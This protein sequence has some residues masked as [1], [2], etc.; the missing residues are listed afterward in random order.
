MKIDRIR[1]QNFHCFEDREF[2]FGSRFNLIIGD[3]ATGKTTLLD[4]LSV[5]LGSLFLGFPEPAAPRNFT[6]D[7][8]RLATYHHGDTWTVEPQFPT[9]VDCSGEVD[10]H[11]GTWHRALNSKDGR[12]TRQE[13]EWIRAEASRLSEAVKQGRPAIL[14]VVSYYGT[15]RLW[16]QLRQT[17]TKA[18]QVDT[19]KPDTRFVGYLD[20]LN[21]AS[22]VKRL[23]EWFKTQEMSALQRSTT[24]QTLEAARRAILSCVPGSSF[25]EFDVSRDQLMI[26]FAEK[27]LPFSFLSDGYRN[28]VAMAADIAIRCASLNPHLQ[29]KSSEETPGV[30]LIDEIDLHLHPRWQRRVVDDLLRTFPKIQFFGTTHSPFVIQSLPP[31]E[32]VQLLNLDDEHAEEFAHKSVEDI[33][34]EIQGVELPQRSKR[35]QDMMHAAERY[36]ALLGQSPPASEEER[37]RLKTE[38]DQLSMPFSD[39]PAYQAFLKVQRTAAGMNGE[40]D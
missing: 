6:S 38:L 24:S 13:A 31:I 28:M 17:K 35:F 18:R 10:G 2:S 40:A 25:V 36:F 34:E 39:D 12:T 8:V 11:P 20:C 15:G 5:G 37:L 3:N 1:L 26:R 14:P 29:E 27:T 23:L 32:G 9:Q 7:E 22:D 30:V 19:L 21:P 4:A 16:V 33:S